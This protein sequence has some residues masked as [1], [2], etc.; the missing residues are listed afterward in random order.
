MSLRARIALARTAHVLLV[1]GILAS[2]RNA[3]AQTIHYALMP[4]SRISEHC[5]SCQPSADPLQGTFDLT[6]MPISSDFSLDALTQIDWQAPGVSIVGSGYAQRL[7]QD[8]LALVAQVRINGT[9]ALLTSGRRQYSPGGRIALVLSTPRGTEPAYTVTLVAA[10]APETGTDTDGDGV[11][12]PRD[13]CPADANRSQT[14]DDRDGVG[15]EC[16]DCEGTFFREAAN[17]AGCSTTQ[18]CP[19]DGPD[20]DQ[21][22]RDQKEYVRCVVDESRALEREGRIT[23]RQALENLRRAVRSGCGRHEIAAR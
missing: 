9:P 20:P 18:N 22:W 3:A 10:P 5:P 4:D 11:S 23:H 14:D 21:S 16:D 17:E 19:C 12:D 2:T 6:P 1:A 7:G 8:E 13:N 15:D